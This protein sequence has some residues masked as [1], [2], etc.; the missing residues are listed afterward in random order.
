M[1]TQSITQDIYLVTENILNRIVGELSSSNT[2]ANLANQRLS[3]NRDLHRA[4]GVFPIV[5]ANIPEEYLG[6]SCELTYGERAIILA[7]QLFALHQQGK[8]QLVHASRRSDDEKQWSNLGLS[9]S[10]LRVKDES[11]AIDRRFNAMIT[12]AN[13]E[14]LANHLR[15]LIKLL[16]RTDTKVDY[17]QLA[18]DLFLF[19][20]GYQNNIRLKWSRDYY[21]H[22]N[23][24]KGEEG[25]DER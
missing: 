2:K 5:F 17:A 15:H 1:A 23:Q 6:E 22:F 16:A 9:L 13:F 7:L 20:I 4:I 14:E 3:I 19:Q 8:E 21:R 25:S 24:K 11:E 12:A 18:Q 10:S